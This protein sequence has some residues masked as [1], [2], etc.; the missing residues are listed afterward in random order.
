MYDRLMA[1]LKAA[2]SDVCAEQELP[3]SVEAQEQV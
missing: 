2:L 3:D 1:A